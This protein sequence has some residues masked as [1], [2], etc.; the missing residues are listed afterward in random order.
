[1]NEQTIRKI[2]E[3]YVAEKQDREYHSKAA[4]EAEN[5]LEAVMDKHIE[6]LDAWTDTIVAAMSLANEYECDGFV[7]GFKRAMQMFCFSRKDVA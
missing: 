5:G 4:I 7:A 1:M 3:N 6:D 2:F